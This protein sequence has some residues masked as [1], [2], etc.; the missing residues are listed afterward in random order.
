MMPEKISENIYEIPRDIKV[1]RIGSEIKKFEMNV[2]AHIYANDYLMELMKRDKTLDQLA[3]MA[4]LPGIYKH[5]IAL[6]DAHQGYGY[7]IGGVTA[8]DQEEGAVC[9]GGVGYDVNC[10]V[11]LLRTNLDFADI[12]PIVP[13]IM[14]N[15]FTDVP[16]GLGSKGRISLNYSQLDD[17]LEQGLV[18]CV[19]NG[20]GWDED[21][22]FCEET[23]CVK[24]ASSAKVSRKAKER[25]IKQVGSLGSGNHFLEVQRV[26][27]IF[28]EEAAKVMG[29]THVDQVTVMVH[30]GPRALGHQTCTDYLQLIEH[31]NREKYHRELPDRELTC[32]L[33]KDPEAQEYLQAMAAAANYGF[34]N[35]QLISH[36]VREAFAKGFGKSPEELDLDPI[37]DVAH[38]IL[39][40]EEHDI[41][42]INRMVN[43]HRKGATRAFPPGHPDIPAKYQSIGQP[44]LIPGSMGTASYLC[45]GQ[46]AAME[47][48]FGS[49]AHGAGREMSRTK[50][51]NKF[52]GRDIERSLAQRGI[53]VKAAS[54]V[55]VAEE[56]PGAYKDIDQVVQVSHDLGIVKKVVRLVPVGVTKG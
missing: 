35:R 40:I 44:V 39:K 34:A 49:T 9:P 24:G 53:S 15:L 6:S 52:R 5:A 45:V 3:N 21:I 17:I 13:Q 51:K 16:S 11:R 8:T 14:E 47:L 1:A 42:G 46:P 55:V 50:A 29:L 7:C 12:N 10:G 27:E 22:T 31:A 48:S 56:A 19:E 20:Y 4:C 30:T 28:D 43:V 32:V 54:L 37:F 41:D 18:W 38:N 25:G 33:G 26:D 23:G 36:W 2:P